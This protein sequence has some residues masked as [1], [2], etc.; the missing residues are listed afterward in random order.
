TLNLFDLSNMLA[1]TLIMPLALPL[2]Y[3]MFVKRAPAWA[4]WS[5]VLV[6]FAASYLLKYQVPP[7]AV[8][9][10]LGWTTPLRPRETGD[11]VL[12]VTTLGAVGFGSLWY[13]AATLLF[14][15]ARRD[16][17]D[18]ARA[19]Q[20]FAN[21][22]TPIDAAAERIENRDE[23]LYRLMGQLCMTFGAF[24]LLLTL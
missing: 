8:R 20:F 10:L 15:G 21:L 22:R 23:I 7:D 13:F 4:A 9:R 11:F 6:G 3:G 17:Q 12:A 2:I 5:T 18:A 14:G 1:G 19:E 16:A 24:I